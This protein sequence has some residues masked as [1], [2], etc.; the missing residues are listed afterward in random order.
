MGGEAERFH[1]VG[2]RKMRGLKEEGKRRGN[3][4]W[5]ADVYYLFP[6]NIQ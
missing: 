4:G 5:Y 1:G 6:V 3:E 2:G